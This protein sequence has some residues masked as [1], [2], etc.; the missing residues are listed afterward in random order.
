MSSGRQAKLIEFRGYLFSSPFG[1]NAIHAF[2]MQFHVLK[3]RIAII[4]LPIFDTLQFVVSIYKKA[5]QGTIS[6]FWN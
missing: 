2:N 3:K 1:F 4:L 6:W 5:S